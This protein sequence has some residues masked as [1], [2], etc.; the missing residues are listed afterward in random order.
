MGNTNISQI[1]RD[2]LRLAYAGGAATALWWA[3][4]G[5]TASADGTAPAVQMVMPWNG[6]VRN[7]YVFTTADPGETTIGVHLDRNLVA[8]FS[9]GFTP[10]GG[11]AANISEVRLEGQFVAGQELGIVIDPTNDPGASY[12]VVGVEYDSPGF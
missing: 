3:Y 4:Q 11:G 6:R 9:N 8:L 10:G 2:A 5:T 1:G 7:A 12:L